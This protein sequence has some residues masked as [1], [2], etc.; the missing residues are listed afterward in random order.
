MQRQP[1][2]YKQPP[3]FAIS[4]SGV[5]YVRSAQSGDLAGSLSALNASVV[6]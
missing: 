5:R 6:C 4:R 1:T 2:I 3:Q